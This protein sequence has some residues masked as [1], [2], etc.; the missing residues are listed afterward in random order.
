MLLI[1]P[2]LSLSLPLF[3]P[4]LLLSPCPFIHLLPPPLFSLP[5]PPFPPPPP[6]THRRYFVQLCSALEHMHSRRV[7]HRGKCSICYHSNTQVIPYITWTLTRSHSPIPHTLTCPPSH[8]PNPPTP[9]LIH[10]LHHSPPS[11]S[12]IPSTTHP[13]SHSSI[14]S[15]T[16]PPSHSP[17][18]SLAHP[19]HTDIKPANVFVTATAVVKLGDLG[20][21]RFFSSKTTA[22]HSLGMILF[23]PDRFHWLLSWLLHK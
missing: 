15:T 21:G 11:H 10:P 13:P 23:T 9:S 12:S 6:P 22:A 4:F 5:P 2:F 7:M 19:L 16:H 20:L 3:F 8:S 1:S 14:P 17:T 18:S